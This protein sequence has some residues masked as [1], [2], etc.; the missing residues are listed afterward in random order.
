MSNASSS[1]P[2]QPGSIPLATEADVVVIGAGPG[3]FSAALRAAREGVSVVVVEK[4]DMPGG[5]HTSGLQGA[6]NTGVGGIHTELMERFER[7]GAIYT[8]TENELYGWAGNPISHYDWYLP[9]GSH[10]SRSSF[11]PDAAGNIMSR[12]LEEAG[13]KCFYG[14]SFTD[15]TLEG[16]GD[17]R[18]IREVII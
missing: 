12:M 17:Q 8:V 2:S 9:P 7:E 5:V 10:F 3:G 4:Y 13:V 14:A 18:S 11:N 16:S 1:L 15:V 6:V